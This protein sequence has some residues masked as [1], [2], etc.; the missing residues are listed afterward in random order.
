MTTLGFVAER[1]NEPNLFKS[2]ISPHVF[3][4]LIPDLLVS[5]FNLRKGP[6]VPFAESKHVPIK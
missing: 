5:A 4:N 3:S 1:K 6:E 2:Y